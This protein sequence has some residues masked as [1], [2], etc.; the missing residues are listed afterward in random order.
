MKT[1]LVAQNYWKEILQKG[2]IAI[3]A[4][5]GNGHDTIF[6]AKVLEGSGAIFA[7]DVQANALRNAKMNFEGALT[8]K[9]RASITLIH[10]SHEH[11]LQPSAKLI[12]YNLG[13]LPGGD[14]KITTLKESTLKSLK[15]GA[16]VVQPKGALSIMC[17]PGHPEG[18]EEERQILEW[19]RLLN[20]QLWDVCFHQWINR[21]EAPSFL[22]IRRK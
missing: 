5:L 18:A 15:H 7:Y 11:F 19:A 2:E 20:P 21:K 1:T 10:G 12:V 13:Y 6:L 17:Y 14:K 9:E 4:T 3:D 22:L 16:T 8:D